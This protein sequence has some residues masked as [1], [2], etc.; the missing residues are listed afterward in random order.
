MIVS[1][2]AVT[3]FSWSTWMMVSSLVMTMPSFYKQSR[4]SKTWDSNIED[5]DHPADYVGVSIKKHHDGF[6]EFT[7]HALIDSIIEDAGIS[8]S[9]TKPV[10][11]KVSL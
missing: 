4:K 7:Q 5:Q 6:Y 2:F 11:A 1:P 10:P 8:D 9:K 3:L